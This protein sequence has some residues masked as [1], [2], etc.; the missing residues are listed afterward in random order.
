[1]NPAASL[2]QMRIIHYIFLVAIVL[3]AYAGEMVAGK[4]SSGV[5]SVAPSAMIYSFAGLGFVDVLL[6]YYFRRAKLRPAVEKLR[7]DSNDSGG[8]I[9]WRQHT[10]V[11]LILALSISLYGFALR[12]LGAPPRVAWG[13]YVAALILLLAWRPN[14]ELPVGASAGIG[15][16]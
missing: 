2:K 8:L 6:A 15:N 7:R 5:T 14:L 4:N 16:Q 11:S 1:M 3:Y 10:L 9:Q 12:F 13:F